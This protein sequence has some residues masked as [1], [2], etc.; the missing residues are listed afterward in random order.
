[1][2]DR[3]RHLGGVRMGYFFLSR[4]GE[5]VMQLGKRVKHGIRVYLITSH[6]Q[7]VIRAAFMLAD[8]VSHHPIGVLRFLHQLVR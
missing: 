6:Q 3:S 4:Q 8:K 7:Q 2:L 1:M 5:P